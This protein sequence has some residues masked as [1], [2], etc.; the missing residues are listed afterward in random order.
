MDSEDSSNES[1][2]SPLR[3]PEPW[4][5]PGREDPSVAKPQ[6]HHQIRTILNCSL[7]FAKTVKPGLL[8]SA[9]ND[10][11]LVAPLRLRGT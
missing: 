1:T 7:R 2:R 10:E 9:R 3:H 6:V 4:R 5:Q 8:R 11:D